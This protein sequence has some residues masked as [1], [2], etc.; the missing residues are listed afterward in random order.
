MV[1]KKYDYLPYWFIQLDA[2]TDVVHARKQELSAQAIDSYR[3]SVFRLY[4]KK[5]SRV[6]SYINTALP[7]EQ[8]SAALKHSGQALGVKAR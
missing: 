7:L 4:L 5:P 3:D 6:Y 8:C 2:P 1:D